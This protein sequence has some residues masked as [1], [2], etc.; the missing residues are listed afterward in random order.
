MVAPTPNLF[1]SLNTINIWEEWT[2][3]TRKWAFDKYWKK[4]FFALIDRMLVSSYILYQQNTCHVLPL[5][6]YK[7]MCNVV[8]ELC[9]KD[10]E[11]PPLE[12]QQRQCNIVQIEGKKEKDCVVCSNHSVPVGRKR[13]CTQ[14]RGC[15]VGVHLACFEH[16]DHTTKKNNFLRTVVFCKDFLLFSLVVKVAQTCL[17][18]HS[19]YLLCHSNIQLPW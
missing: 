18:L 9:E 10:R 3:W 16:L 2:C 11:D 14:C 5:S 4:C 13:S 19:L 8:Q 12:Q 15:G 1:W 7:F 6:Q 17:L